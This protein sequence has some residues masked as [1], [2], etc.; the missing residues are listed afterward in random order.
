MLSLLVGKKKGKQEKI[1]QEKSKPSRPKPKRVKVDSHPKEST[2][3]AVAHGQLAGLNLLHT[4][5]LG[6]SYNTIPLLM[7]FLQCGKRRSFQ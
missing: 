5:V 6:T 2:T 3:G 4:C 1:K 7:P